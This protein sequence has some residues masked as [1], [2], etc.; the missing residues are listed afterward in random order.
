MCTQLVISLEHHGR[1]LHKASYGDLCKQCI[2][3]KAQKAAAWAVIVQQLGA[4]IAYIVIIADVLQPIFGLSASSPESLLCDRTLYQVGI[5]VCIIFP[6]C[7]LR[8]MDMLKYT[9]L[10]ALCCISAFVLVVSGLG[11]WSLVDSD[12]RSHIIMGR[13]NQTGD[14]YHDGSVHGA[15]DPHCLAVTPHTSGMDIRA[16]N[17]TRASV[18][19]HFVPDNDIKWWPTSI[20]QIGSAVPII[21]F[22]YARPSAPACADPGRG[23]SCCCASGVECRGGLTC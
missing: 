12:T 5:A 18:H 1:I 16:S 8:N 4:C 20:R 9:S 14:L 2:N 19:V 23:C 15:E 7:L 21:C 10:A 17:E 6:L 3:D 11:L 13:G 22:A